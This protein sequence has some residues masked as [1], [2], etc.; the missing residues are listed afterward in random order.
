MEARAEMAAPAS[1]EVLEALAARGPTTRRLVAMAAKVAMVVQ[2][3]LEV[4]EVAGRRRVLVLLQ[5]LKSCT[6]RAIRVCMVPPDLVA[7]AQHA[8]DRAD[9]L[10]G[11]LLPS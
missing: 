3:G 5:R 8:I 6:E 11:A 7:R 9:V 2:V 10:I 4:A 1:L